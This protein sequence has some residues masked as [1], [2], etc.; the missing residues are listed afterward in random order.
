MV[1]EIEKRIDDVSNIKYPSYWKRSHDNP[2]QSSLRC[3]NI[4]IQVDEE[5]M[6]NWSVARFA[7]DLAV[8][9]VIFRSEKVGARMWKTHCEILRTDNDEWKMKTTV[10]A[11]AA[12]R[13]AALISLLKL[14]L[15]AHRLM[16]RMRSNAA[17]PFVVVLIIIS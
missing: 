12:V 14:W 13:C 15:W 4:L 3:N 10:A 8:S 9:F 5:A 11:A 6:K 1:E 7:Y 2:S 16:N 17:S